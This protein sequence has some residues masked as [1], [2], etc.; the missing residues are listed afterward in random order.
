MFAVDLRGRG[1]SEG[2]RFYV[3]SFAEYV[4]DVEIVLARARGRFPDLPTF[5]LG[6]SAGGV[7]ACLVALAHGAEL[8]GLIS[9]SF[10][11][12]LP[13]PQFTLTII[14]GLSHV[15]PH[16]P[17]LRLKNTDFS[18]DLAMAAAM[19]ADPLIRGETQPSETLAAL[20]RADDRLRRDVAQLS[21][22]VLIL[23][24]TADKA[25][26]PAGS[27]EFHDII[28]SR[29]KTLK[30]YQGAFHDLLGDVMKNDVLLGIRDWIVAHI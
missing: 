8:A 12:E 27:A 21:L 14:K 13:A 16:A 15:A 9:E 11:Y 7:V 5:L 10:A 20:M 30:L 18:R 25:A 19:D 2:D 24:G 4:D 22:P 6:H 23:H 26:K 29:D 17:I 1:R 28:A 3:D